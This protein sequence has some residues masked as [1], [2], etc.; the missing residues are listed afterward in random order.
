MRFTLWSSVEGCEG[1]QWKKP[2]LSPEERFFFGMETLWMNKTHPFR[3]FL[4]LSIGFHCFAFSSLSVLLPDLKALQISNLNIEIS[5]LPSQR[6][7]RK[8][9]NSV[10]NGLNPFPPKALGQ[11][12][13]S[14][15]MVKEKEKEAEAEAPTPIKVDDEE[16]IVQKEMLELSMP[17]KEEQL[18]R[19]APTENESREVSIS[20][21]RSFPIEIESKER[22]IKQEERTVVGSLG[23]PIP[24]DS[25]SERLQMAI[26]GPALS[27]TDI[28]FVQPKYAENPKPLY[29]REA[30]RKGYEGEVLLRVEVLSNGRVGEVEVKRSSGYELLDR[31]AMIAVKQWKFIPAKKGETPVPSW[32][33]IPIVFQL[34]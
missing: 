15:K 12:E 17:Q 2:A 20:E 13:G 31:S 14:T 16:K 18:L 28:V 7:E 4:F 32:V 29:P 23:N 1:Y 27:D 6:E 11:E 33:N 22:K 9:R 10:G 8:V 30:K 21:T 34:R 26:K 24:K 25:P 19:P 3:L 5:L